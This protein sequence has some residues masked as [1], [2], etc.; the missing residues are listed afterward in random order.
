MQIQSA[1]AGTAIVNTASLSDG[2]G[3]VTALQANAI[4]N[5]GYRL[6]IN[7]GAIFTNTPTVTL[8]FGWNTDDGITAYQVSNDGGFTPGSGTTGWL[9]VNPANPTHPGWELA[10]YGDL[11]LPQAVYIRFQNA[12]GTPFG[13]FQE[14]IILDPVPPQ[15]DSLELVPIG[16]AAAVLR[17]T[18]GK[19]VLVRVIARDDNSGVLEVQLSNRSDFAVASS[20]P[21]AGSLTEIAWPLQPSGLVYG[22]V[23]DRAGN[24]S[25]VA[26]AQ[27]KPCYSVYLP[28]L[29][30]STP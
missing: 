6:T 24:P 7:E 15:V 25:T 22:R 16:G 1:P 23:L 9:P 17:P 20:Y 14:D 5:P 29:Q 18:A 3:H 28:I 21:V 30:R 13:P 12:G 8:R 2:A 10:A 11:R 26:S 27:G 19:S 4:F